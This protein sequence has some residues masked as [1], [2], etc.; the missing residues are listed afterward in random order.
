MRKVV[1]ATLVGLGLSCSGLTGAVIAEATGP[2]IP[3]QPIGI[4]EV[5]IDDTQSISAHRLAAFGHVYN[6][7]L[8]NWSADNEATNTLWCERGK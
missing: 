7:F 5:Q 4:R 3:V 2:S 8:G 1:A 6:C